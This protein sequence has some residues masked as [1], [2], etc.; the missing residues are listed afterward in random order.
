MGK[1]IEK[2]A[3]DLNQKVA[4]NRQKRGGRLFP[5]E[6]IESAKLQAS[7]YAC[8]VNETAL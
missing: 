6:E 1:F 3:F 5:A 7:E 2:K 8:C 4:F